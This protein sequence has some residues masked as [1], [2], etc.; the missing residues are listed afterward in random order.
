MLKIIWSIADRYPHLISRL[1][2]QI[3]LM[4]NFGLNGCVPWLTNTD[5][6]LCLFFF[7]NS[8]EDVNHF[9]S[10]CPSFRDN[11]KTL[12]SKLRPKIIA[13]NPSDG[14]QISHFVTS[15]NRQQ[16]LYCYQEFFSPL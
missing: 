3:R 11:F 2:V 5:S 12:W 7:K 16:K 10:G 1:H 15:L 8:V 9:L 14:T 6:K 4:G 13:F